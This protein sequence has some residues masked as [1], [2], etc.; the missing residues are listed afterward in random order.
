MCGAQLRLGAAAF[1]RGA[2]LRGGGGH[3][4]R[5][6]KQ[7]VGIPLADYTVKIRMGRAEQLL[8]DERLKLTDLAP[9]VGYASSSHFASAFKKYSGK[10]PKEYRERLQRSR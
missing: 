4:N 2:A 3:L 7:H 5:Q 8:P 6:F 9:L 1:C 10:S